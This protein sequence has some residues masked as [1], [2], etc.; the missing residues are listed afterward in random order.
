M[1]VDILVISRGCAAAAS[2]C[3]SVEV[4]AEVARIARVA[5]GIASLRPKGIAHRAHLPISGLAN[6][7]IRLVNCRGAISKDGHLEAGRARGII[8]SEDGVRRRQGHGWRGRRGRRRGRRRVLGDALAARPLT[9]VR[10]PWVSPWLTRVITGAV[11]GGWAAVAPDGSGAAVG[12]GGAIHRRRQVKAD[13]DRWRRRWRKAAGSR[14]RRA[15]SSQRHSQHER[16][17]NH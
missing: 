7:R 17:A 2:G 15:Y 1:A 13:G 9:A 4:A 6:G 16:N 8:R 12:T 14:R 10:P 3:V 5:A 11:G